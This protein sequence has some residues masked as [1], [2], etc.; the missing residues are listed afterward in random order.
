MRGMNRAKLAHAL[1]VRVEQAAPADRLP[2]I[3]E[4]RA[5]AKNARAMHAFARQV[6][7]RRLFRLF[8][9]AAL[10]ASPRE[11]AA[12]SQDARVERIWLDMRVQALV[13]TSVSLVQA[14]PVWELGYTGRGVRVAI[15]D[16]GVDTD[17]PDLQGR[18]AASRDFTDEGLKDESG[19][20][21]HVAGIVAGDGRSSRGK[22]RGVAPRASLLAGK[23]LRRDG[24]GLTSEVI[25][26]LEWA[27]EE[28]AEVANLSLGTPG[29]ADG[30]DPLS[31]AC[32]AAAEKGLIVCAAA[33]NAGPGRSTIS[34]P[35]AARKVIAVGASNDEDQL[36]EFSAHGPTS[37]GRDKPDLVAPGVGIVSLRAQ[38]TAMGQAVDA[39]YTSSSGTSMASPHVTGAVALLL[40]AYPQLSP[41]DVKKLLWLSAYNLGQPKEAQGGGRLDALGAFKVAQ[42]PRGSGCTWPLVWLLGRK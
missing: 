13:D 35:A 19:H 5:E 42:Q 39:R 16:S 20:G 32:D 18:V 9:S 6:P 37:D 36:A 21:T 23:V 41:E 29:P 3:V 14:P 33:G 1:V 24:G 25:A 34:I 27:L 12:L 28:K 2:V 10:E 4:F 31:R 7:V 17:H 30:H 15:L 22:Y 8:P 11:I 26:G 40:Q 38:G